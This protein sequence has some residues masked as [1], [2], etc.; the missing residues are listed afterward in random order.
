[1]SA[2][3]HAWQLGR[4]SLLEADTLAAVTRANEMAPRRRQDRAGEPT[5]GWRVNEPEG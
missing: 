1:M 4:R 2:Q 5:H 3:P